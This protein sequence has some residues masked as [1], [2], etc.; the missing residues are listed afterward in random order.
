MA[1]IVGAL[2]D[3]GHSYGGGQSHSSGGFDAVSI[4]GALSD[5]HH[6]SGAYSNGGGLDVASIVSAVGQSDQGL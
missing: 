3:S 2:G 6:D 1:P 4:V 5:S